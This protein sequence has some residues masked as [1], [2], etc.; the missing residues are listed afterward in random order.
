LGLPRGTTVRR[1]NYELPTT[2]YDVRTVIALAPS[3]FSV[4]VSL[5][6]MTQTMSKATRL[7]NIYRLDPL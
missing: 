2:L 5:Y 6:L 7:Q 1:R 4:V 3:N